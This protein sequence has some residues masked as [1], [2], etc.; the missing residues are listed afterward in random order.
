MTCPTCKDTGWVR[1][2]DCWKPWKPC[3]NG[4]N[5]KIYEAHLGKP[6]KRKHEWLVPVGCSMDSGKRN[7]MSRSVDDGILT[8][9]L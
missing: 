2:G 7:P 3:P 9:T 6:Y 8:E 4:C 1:T 5:K